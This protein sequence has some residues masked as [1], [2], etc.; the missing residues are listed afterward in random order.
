MTAERRLQNA[1][2]QVNRFISPELHK[3]TKLFVLQGKGRFDAKKSVLT[4]AGFPSDNEES[5]VDLVYFYQT[6]NFVEALSEINHL[7]SPLSL[8]YLKVKATD[9][10]MAKSMD[11]A[12]SE[13]LPIAVLLASSSILDSGSYTVLNVLNGV[14][15]RLM[16]KL[17][18]ENC[19][20]QL[21]KLN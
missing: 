1:L 13:E 15:P 19:Q 2:V 12:R 20:F 18:R 10:S 11:F 9:E 6:G 17:I 4:I 5:K 8:Q 21:F 16:Y 3:R 14:N 7:D